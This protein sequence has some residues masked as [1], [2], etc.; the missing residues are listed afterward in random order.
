MLTPMFIFDTLEVLS[1]HLIFN[2][3]CIHKMHDLGDDM[4]LCYTKS[5]NL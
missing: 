3:V 1:E 2:S 4:V 5:F